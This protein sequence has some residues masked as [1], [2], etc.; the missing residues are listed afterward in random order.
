[1]NV[2]RVRS[3][4]S[5]SR[6]R[7]VFGFALASLVLFGLWRVYR[8]TAGEPRAALTLTAHVSTRVLDRKGRDLREIPALDGARARPLALEDVGERLV[9]ATLAAEDRDFYEH[10]GVDGAAVVR[11]VGQNLVAG[12]VVSGAS[13]ITQQLVKL[14]DG[15]GRPEQRTVGAKL[16]EA[17]RAQNLEDA[18]DKRTILEAYLNRLPYG[19]GLTGPEAAARAYF[20]VAAADLSWARAAYLAVLPRAPS[21]LDVYDHPERVLARQRPLL[22]ALRDAGVLA[23]SD[24]ERALAE[25]VVARPL[26]RPFRAPHFVDTLVR[27]GK[28]GVAGAVTTT[29]DRELQDDLEADVAAHA[30][31][32]RPFGASSA[33]LLV[34]DNA[35][36]DVLAW[37]GSAGYDDVTFAGQVDLVR[38]PRQPGS[39]LKPFVYGLAFE[40]GHHAAEVLADVRT[41]FGGGASTWAPNNFDGSFL[42]P[43]SAREALA[44]SLNVPAVRLAAELPNGLFL[45]RLHEL[46]FT[47]LS[48]G[49]ADYGLS[50]VLGGG[51]VTL[52]ELGRAY[53]T[54]A[55]GGRPTALRL[56][57]SDADSSPAPPVM[58]PEIAAQL[59][60]ILSDPLARLRGL[61]G[62]G[63]FELGFPVAVK[64]GTSSGFRDAWTAGYTA[65]RTV[66]VWVGNPDGAPTLGLAGANGA[67]PLFATAMRRAMRDV[68][69]RAPL[70][71]ASLLEEHAVCPLSGERPTEACPHAVARR[72]AKG[73]GP[74]ADCTLH[75]HLRREAPRFAGDS[76]FVAEPGGPLV[77]VALPDVFA[78]W[79][80]ER[81]LGAPGEDANGA[82]WL[83]R[84]AVRGLD[85]ASPSELRVATPSDGAVYF[86]SAPGELGRVPVEV[87][88]VGAPRA[89]T[90]REIEVVVD[91]AVKG[92]L[93][94][95]YRIALALAPG[96]HRIWARPL[97]DAGDVRSPSVRIAVR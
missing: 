51:E 93:S 75:V 34:L 81:P 89:E 29:L 19:H 20:G 49:A 54:L 88:L 24:Y 25:S 8:G 57:A 28:L 36:G 62:A 42:G 46:G 90:P 50:L 72:F 96:D 45:G 7:V 4:L 27:R 47:S 17:A 70:F 73:H 63:P 78:S 83:A 65:E 43:V 61:H 79:L 85:A 13:T 84:S 33:A 95:P 18:V 52:E 60:E 32:L 71:D 21:A 5:P 41:T 26:V 40:R 87:E 97:G 22:L 15:Q 86:G 39:T 55:R 77:G 66:V 37:I 9:L 3:A 92:R 30:S 56:L 2:L 11:A 68:P 14:L 6:R 58:P 48:A 1:M 53:A 38:S 82:P 76:G 74:H 69:T 23:P 67:G 31:L 16:V 91:G 10:G 94:P 80:A 64:T 59:S 44:G 35:T 12:R